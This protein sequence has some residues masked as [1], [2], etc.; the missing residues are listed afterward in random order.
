MRRTAVTRSR[1]V[2][3]P[4]AQP[5]GGLSSPPPRSDSCTCP[6]PPP[7]PRVVLAEER[8]PPLFVA[9]AFSLPGRPF[10]G[11]PAAVVLILRAWPTGAWMQALALELGFPATAFVRPRADGAWGVRF[12]NPSTELPMCGHASLAIAHVLLLQQTGSPTTPPALPLV[13]RAVQLRAEAS[14]AAIL[15][16]AVPSPEGGE[17]LI[18]LTLSA[19]PPLE[20][21]AAEAAELRPALIRALGLEGEAATP[22]DSEP[23]LWIGRTRHDTVVRLSPW[24]FAAMKPDFGAITALPGAARILTV[25]TLGGGRGAASSGGSLG[26]AR[27]SDPVNSH[28]PSAFDIVSR[29]FQP[30]N[31]VPEDPV[32]GAAHCQLA[33]LWEAALPLDDASPGDKRIYAL[34][35]SPRGGRLLLGLTPPPFDE[36]L[37]AGGGAGRL[38]FLEGA[39]ETAVVGRLTATPTSTS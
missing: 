16:E 33:C 14:G 30:R 4:S 27:L 11:N 3:L 13:Q 36:S 37:R 17:P 28:D 7:P 1:R 19:D 23:L 24:A 25:T 15:A 35:A 39:C 26:A 18:R 31:G 12:F 6:I 38:V 2:T 32:C 22:A 10:S 9:R 21:S 29:V 34:Q 8:L 5:A 20:V